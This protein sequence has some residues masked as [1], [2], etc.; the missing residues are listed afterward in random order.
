MNDRRLTAVD[1]NGTVMTS[2]QSP[3]L[4]QLNCQPCANGWE[5][6][7]PKQTN[8]LLIYPSE[9]TISGKIWSDTFNALD[10][11]DKASDW[12]SKVLG[13]D[14]R[15]ALWRPTARHSNKYNLATGFADAAPILIASEASMQQGCNWADIPYDARRF[16]PNII[17]SGVDAFEE[18]Q[19]NRFRIND[20]VFEMLE[21]C[22]RCILTTRNP[23]TGEA[24]PDKQP[25]KVLMQKHTNES[26]KPIMGMNAKLVSGFET[27]TITVGDK[28][29]LV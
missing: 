16:R 8:S 27:T 19:W 3:E 9:L 22:S 26:G 2:R 23:D 21:S 28:L 24:H 11:G 13:Q 17:I 15:V 25:M 10:G 1:R 4:L 5:L 6:S 29:K 18:E 14:C 12:L 7:H 20:T